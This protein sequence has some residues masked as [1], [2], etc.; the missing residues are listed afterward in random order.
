MATQKQEIRETVEMQIMCF[1]CPCQGL[2]RLLLERTPLLIVQVK[3]KT[4]HR[5]W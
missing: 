4:E 3:H 2:K 5:L 1:L